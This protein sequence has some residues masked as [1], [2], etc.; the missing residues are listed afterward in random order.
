MDWLVIITRAR[1]LKEYFDKSYKC[2]NIERP[3]KDETVDK[4]LRILFERLEEIGKLFDTYYPSLTPNHKT[5]AEAFF[6]DVRDR[7]VKLLAKRGLEA[8]IP[9]TFHERLTYNISLMNTQPST[10]AGNTETD[11]KGSDADA[12]GKVSE[13]PKMPQTIVE[14]LNFASKII[15]DFD[16][17][18]ENLRSFL[19]ALTLLDSVKDVHELV[20]VNLI[21][22]K[23]KGTARNLISNET[24]IEE[25]IT[26]L[27]GTVKGDSVE[28]I[29][30]KLLNVRQGGKNANTYISEIDALTKSL[31]SAYITDGLSQQLAQRYS[32]QAAVKAI[33]RNATNERVKLIMESGTFST[34]NEVTAK[35]V[36]S[37]TEAYGQQN[38]VLFTT[39]NQGNRS[40]RG[41]RGRGNW[42]R[43]PSRGNNN[44][45]RGNGRGNF[46]NNNNNNDYGNTNSNR[47]RNRQNNN[48]N[49]NN[50]RHVTEN[51]S[52][53]EL[54]P[55]N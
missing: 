47:G 2:L 3:T 1:Q 27:S 33:T 6:A 45:Y 44:N 51:I 26:T 35:F 20:A 21:K 14:F 24:T 19:D 49:R 30:A 40:K 8:K 18:P 17:K 12:K 38:S 9:L 52:G 34:M 28:V 48:G 41:S 15:P 39:S 54:V 53:N 7:L 31:E 36:N 10:S 55:L 5:A 13:D 37:C 50:V 43:R 29:S 46:N 22:T 42:Q 11:N 32:T 25:V 16:G 4:H 23:L